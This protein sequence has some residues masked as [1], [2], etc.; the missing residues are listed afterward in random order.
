MKRPLSGACA[1]LIAVLA[2]SPV[3][4][5]G[6]CSGTYAATLL[7]PL[8]S[9]LV[10]GL[11]LRDDSPRNIGLAAQFRAG[12]QKAGVTV[13]DVA[14]TQLTLVA[15]MSGPAGSGD[16]ARPPPSDSSFSWWNGGVDRQLPDQSRFGG[17]RR[18]AGPMTL[19]LRAQLRTAPDAPVAWVATL[20]CAV[21]G[22]DE[23]QLAFDIGTV[24]GGAI[25]RRVEQTAF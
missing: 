19:Q 23:R 22:N 25:G 17:D 13:N 9:P 11:V 2:A 7:S 15:T 21:Q 20:Q 14:N 16:P 10:V 8:P 12:M 5:M 1:A 6:S 24:I 18:N 3:W 4:A